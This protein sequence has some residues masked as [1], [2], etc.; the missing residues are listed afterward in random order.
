[1]PVKRRFLHKMIIYSFLC[2]PWK[3]VPVD[4]NETSV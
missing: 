2:P 4:C 3:G 1:M